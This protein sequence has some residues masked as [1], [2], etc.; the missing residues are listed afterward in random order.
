MQV[1]QDTRDK[2]KYAKARKH[3]EGHRTLAKQAKNFNQ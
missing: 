2:E 1:Q 3:H